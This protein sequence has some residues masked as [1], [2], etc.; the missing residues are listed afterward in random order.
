M[1]E[2][3]VYGSC[4]HHLLP[5]SLEQ[6]EGGTFEGLLITSRL[7]SLFMALVRL[8]PPLTALVSGT[9]GGRDF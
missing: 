5:W 2:Q 1:L 9:G 7:S 4:A 3:F 6:E 8:K